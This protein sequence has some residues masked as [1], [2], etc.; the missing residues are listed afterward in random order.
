MKLYIYDA[1]DM[2]HIATI[3]GDTNAACERAAADAYGLSDKYAATYTPAFGAVDGLVEND[4]AEQINA[5]R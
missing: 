4:D 3:T 2:Q 1:A 5:A